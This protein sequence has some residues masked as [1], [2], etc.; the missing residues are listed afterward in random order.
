MTLEAPPR[1]KI[2]L[3][4]KDDSSL[5]SVRKFAEIVEKHG[6]VLE[7][8]HV[9]NRRHKGKELSAR[10]IAEGLGD[11]DLHHK[12]EM[13]TLA[14]EDFLQRFDVIL[15]CKLPTIFQLKFLLGAWRF[16]GR[17]PCFVTSFPGI[18]FTPELGMNVRR[19]SDII[20]VNTE[21]DISR[22]VALIPA[23]IQSRQKIIR[24]SPFF[25]KNAPLKKTTELRTVAFFSQSVMPKTRESRLYIMKTFIELA[26]RNPNVEYLF[27]LRHLKE[28]NKVH[29]HQEQFSYEELHDELLSGGKLPN[30]KFTAE[31]IGNL[32]KKVDLAVTCASTA[33][34]EALGAGVPA[35]FFN[36]YPGA[37]KEDHNEK[38]EDFLKGSGIS[39]GRAELKLQ[40]YREPLEGWGNG[41][42]STERNLE[43][44]V[45]AMLSFDHYSKPGSPI[46]SALCPRWVS[47]LIGKL[48]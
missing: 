47:D 29:T 34:V 3:V 32:F 20:C 21:A 22:Y 10:Q 19:F 13:R 5:L 4:F 38:L 9:Y 17:R 43:Q 1:L 35:L 28:E 7:F 30:L 23:K 39:V 12:L 31:Y 36:K 40:T 48:L 45:N 6:F 14:Q 15:T 18:E 44:L 11:W 41:I 46:L 37:A 33:G 42:L 25:Y 16:K 2:L 26:Q 27:K 24:F 8:C